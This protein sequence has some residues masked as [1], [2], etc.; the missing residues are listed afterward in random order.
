MILLLYGCGLRTAELCALDV[1]DIVR[2]RQELTVRAGKGD[3]P[4]VVPIPCDIRQ[5]DLRGRFVTQIPIPIARC[6]GTAWHLLGS[7]GP[8]Q[9]CCCGPIG[10]A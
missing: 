3:R 7:H 8:A 1:A 2:E 4:R 9:A 5:L 10:I 6:D